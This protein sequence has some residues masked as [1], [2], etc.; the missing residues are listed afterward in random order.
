MDGDYTI[1]KVADGTIFTGPRLIVT[2][3]DRGDVMVEDDAERSL[4]R[5]VAERIACGLPDHERLAQNIMAVN[6]DDDVFV[7]V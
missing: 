5:G 2:D 7:L 4:T 3:L 6:V 1:T